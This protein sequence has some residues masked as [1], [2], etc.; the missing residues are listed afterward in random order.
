MTPGR[1]YQVAR[2]PHCG[3]GRQLGSARVRFVLE[4]QVFLAALLARLPRAVLRRLRL[5]VRPDT[6]LRWHR[7]LMRQRHAVASRRRRVGRP[8]TCASIR[9]LVL[10]LVSENPPWAIGNPR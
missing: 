2:T 10:R 7:D 9:Q 8:R 6:V 1:T 4:D 3:P 5:V